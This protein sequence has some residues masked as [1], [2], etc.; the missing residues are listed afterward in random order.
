MCSRPR[1]FLEAGTIAIHDDRW[2]T[3]PWGVNGGEPGARSR[4]WLERAD[5]TREM[6]GS[7]V[8]DVPV[9][10]GDLLHFVTWGGG[11]WGDPLARD[12]SLVGL[13]V[14]RGLITVEGAR[15]YGVVCDEEGVVDETATD[16]LRADLRSTR[17]DPLPTFDNGPGI[18][19]I[20]AN[21]LEE[22]GLPAPRPPLAR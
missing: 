7:K 14:L 8:H 17:P 11:G 1:G 10:V 20:L 4:K 12:A 5:G 9:A 16:A 19:T 22:T 21:A 3:Y 18:E 15:R 13:E 2:L 6:L